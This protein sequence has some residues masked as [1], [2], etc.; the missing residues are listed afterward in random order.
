MSFHFK[1]HTAKRGPIPVVRFLVVQDVLENFSGG[2][3][4]GRDQDHQV[5]LPQ[6]GRK[7]RIGGGAPAEGH[8]DPGRRGLKRTEHQAPPGR[9]GGRRVAGG[10]G[11]FGLK[12]TFVKVAEGDQIFVPGKLQ[13]VTA[14]PPFVVQ[15]AKG[16]GQKVPENASVFLKKQ[17]AHR[18]RPLS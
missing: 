8:F 13:A 4:C 3:R 1:H 12:K 10:L 9:K 5:G 6:V 16:G 18:V 11:V 7:V 15:Q 2:R 17:Y 14:S